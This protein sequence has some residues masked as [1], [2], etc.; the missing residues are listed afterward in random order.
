M[1]TFEWIML[2]IPFISNAFVYLQAYKIW[3]RQSHDDVSFL[4]ATFSVVSAAIWGYYG[5][6]INSV[7]LMLSGII[8]TVGF[9]LIV[10]MKLFIPSKTEN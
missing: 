2:I 3:E 9:M 1:P 6:R 5:F 4:T 8:A 10:Y 7:P